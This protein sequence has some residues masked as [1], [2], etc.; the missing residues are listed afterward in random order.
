[1]DGIY[2]QES[3]EVNPLN[4]H[5]LSSFFSYPFQKFVLFAEHQQ[6]RTSFP[7]AL[8]F[9]LPVLWEHPPATQTL[10][11]TNMPR[12]SIDTLTK[13]IALLNKQRAKLEAAKAN[14]KSKK[15]K[16]I[17]ALMK[18]QGVTLADLTG[19]SAKPAKAGGKRGRPAKA[20]SKKG[21]APAKYKNPESGATWT[22]VGRPPVWILEAEKGGKNRS[23]FL[24]ASA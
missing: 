15:A 10:P 18:K 2:F 17:L 22:G 13:K 4:N 16:K 3:V 5:L 7:G 14:D 21:A 8:K 11:L 23:S 19:G 24:I 20:G 1:M 9:S 12:L 6:R